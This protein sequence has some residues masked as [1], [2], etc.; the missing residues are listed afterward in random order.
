LNNIADQV[1]AARMNMASAVNHNNDDVFEP[2]REHRPANARGQGALIFISGWQSPAPK[3]EGHVRFEREEFEVPLVAPFHLKEISLGPTTVGAWAAD[4]RIDRNEDHSAYGNQSHRWLFPRRLRLE[5][6]V[7]IENYGPDR[8]ALTPL[9][10]PT[11]EGDLA[12]WDALNWK[13][14]LISIPSDLEAFAE[15]L[16]RHHPET[17]KEGRPVEG[18]G[19]VYRFSPVTVS[20]KGRDLLG[21]FQLFRSLPEALIFLTNPYWLSVIQKLCPTEPNENPERVS[22]LAAELRRAMAQRIEDIDFDRLARRAM[23]KTATWM[24]ADSKSNAS[25]SYQSLIASL[26]NELRRDEW[27]TTLEQSVEYLRDRSFLRQGYGWSCEVCQHPNWVHLEDIVPILHCDICRTKQSAPVCGDKNVHFRL[28]P[29]VATAFSSSSSQGPV[30][31]ALSRL[32][33][34]ASWSFMFA[35]ALDIV[36]PGEREPF[37]D[38]DLLASVDGEVYLLEVKRSFA[39]VDEREVEKLAELVDTLRPDFAG[40][41]VQRPRAECSLDADAQQRIQREFAV[42]DVRFLLWASDDPDRRGFPMDI[43]IQFGRTMEWSAW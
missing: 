14:P 17:P 8:H 11:E 37:T 33:N 41:A 43:P 16:G 21:V 18:L 34:R 4:L 6:A 15:G 23:G 13:R 30:A 38:V 22:D 24:H 3:A 29:F 40:F 19:L 25:I 31:W 5:L 28:N 35:P 20:D 12:I 10:K 27:R 2:L 9:A 1:R 39:G 26:P 42:N 32:A 7:R 36:K